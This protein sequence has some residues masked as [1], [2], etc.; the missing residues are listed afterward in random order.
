MAN[1]R[2][3]SGE[4][5]NRRIY[6]RDEPLLAGIPYSCHR[7]IAFMV[8]M[9]TDRGVDNWR[10]NS[11]THNVHRFRLALFEDVSHA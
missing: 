1:T 8:S 10:L 7:A 11:R 9:D 2:G 3:P 4:I 6:R 5:F